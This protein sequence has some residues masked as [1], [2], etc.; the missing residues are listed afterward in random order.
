MTIRACFGIGILAGIL[1]LTWLAIDWIPP[2][3]LTVNHMIVLKRHILAYARQN[4][5]LPRTLVDLHPAPGSRIDVEDGWGHTI[6][7]I[8]LPGDIV[9]MTS[10]PP[11]GHGKDI[12]RSFHSKNASKQWADDSDEYFIEEPLALKPPKK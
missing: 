10:H 12:V 8:L 11:D 2:D 3:A 6:E 7:Y 1:T 5:S 4:N 9:Q